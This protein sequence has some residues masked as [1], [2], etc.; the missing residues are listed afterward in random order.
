MKTLESCVSSGHIRQ[1]IE[2]MVK[3]ITDNYNP[4]K[5]LLFGSQAR[6]EAKR[7]SDVDLF[8][9]MPNGTDRMETA[10][11]MMGLMC[12]MHV[13]KDIFVGTPKDVEYEKNFRRFV[14]HD[15]LKEGIDLI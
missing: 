3:R 10:D 5:I 11:K 15:A 8:V 14:A 6:G 4:L 1:N 2:E 7:H 12:D 9:I 13:P